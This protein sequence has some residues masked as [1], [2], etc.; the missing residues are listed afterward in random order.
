MSP[1]MTASVASLTVLLLAT[2]GTDAR[3]DVLVSS[4][5]RQQTCFAEPRSPS[6]GDRALCPYTRT[7]DVKY[8]RIPTTIP[9][10]TCNCPGS[11]C[12]QTGDFHCQEIREELQVAYREH[13]RRTTLRNETFT[14]AC[15]CITTQARQA[16]LERLTR[17][18]DQYG[19][20]YGG[21][22]RELWR[23]YAVRP[24]RRLRGFLGAP[25]AVPQLAHAPEHQL[26][27]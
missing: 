12:S 18:H 11:R 6:I 3:L 19:N 17:V 23:K 5:R 20:P 16:A 2:C 22:V 7:V 8:G 27:A 13:A 4:R 24:Y 25:T 10:V 1:A 9:T 21:Q 15:A 26:Q 14:F